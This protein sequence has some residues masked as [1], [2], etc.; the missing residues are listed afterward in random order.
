MSTPML[1][2]IA[3]ARRSVAALTF[4][5]LPAFAQLTPEWIAT[6]PVGTSLS[7]GIGDYVV[8]EAGIVYVTGTTGSG[9]FGLDVVTAAIGPN[10]SLLWQV[11]YDGPLH[12]FDLASGIARGPGG[13]LYVTG[14]TQGP[15]FFANVLLLKYAAA[16]GALLDSVVWSSGPATSEYGG[17]V[18]VDALG[19]VYVAGGTAGDGTDA[20]ILKFDAACEMQWKR[21]WDGAAEEPYSLDSAL[22]VRVDPDGDVIVL[23]HGVTGSNQPDFVVVKYAPATGATIWQASWGDN[24]GDTPRDMELDADGDIYITGTSSFF[25]S[26]L[27]STIRLRGTDGT[28]LWNAHDFFANHAVARG[29]A[30]DGLGG[31]YVTGTVDPDTDLSNDNDNIYTFKLGAADGVPVWTH[32]YGGSVKW[33]RDE[34]SDVVVDPAGH[35]FVGGYTN[36]PPYVADMITLV[37]DAKSGVEVDR[38]II[39]GGPGL[40]AESGFLAFDADYNLLNGGGPVNPDTGG[41]A[42]SL[43]K[44]TTLASTPYQL[45]LPQLKAGSGGTFAVKYATPLSA[46]FFGYS[47]TGT[48]AI[49]FPILNV[50]LGLANPFLLASGLADGSG[51]YSVGL[52]VPA[53]IGGLTV[54][55]QAVQ[56]SGATPVVKR[57]I[58]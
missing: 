12:G 40:T 56:M 39:P 44:F 49:P 6:L 20:L 2:V 34:P 16:T 14:H 29:L 30:L 54:W 57:T 50:T 47:L 41:V 7:S 53:G 58:Q 11:T 25:Q 33:Q 55:F 46:Q 5:S 26:A 51:S 17:S 15:D 28:L 35:V 19:G 18:A 37:L 43:V 4:L 42:I 3:I 13:V 23:I 48:A 36:S 9:P 1:S 24:G 22:R 8:D 10:G 52:P 31:V 32:L 21:T 38:H 27:F 45:N